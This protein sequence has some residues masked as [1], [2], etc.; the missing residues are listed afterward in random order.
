MIS[1]LSSSS[2]PNQA[3][4]TLITSK[5]LP[6]IPIQVSP[7]VPSYL[8]LPLSTQQPIMSTQ[9]PTVVPVIVAMPVPDTPE[10]PK[11]NGKEVERFIKKV[12]AHRKKAGI[13]DEDD[14]VDYLIGYCDNKTSDTTWNSS[15]ENRTGCGRRPRSDL[16]YSTLLWMN[17]RKSLTTT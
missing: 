12:Q 15:R 7:S 10:A 4:H 3:P 9:V 14:L 11:F 2:N 17:P 5:S 16:D 13:I 1:S 6:Q 8:I